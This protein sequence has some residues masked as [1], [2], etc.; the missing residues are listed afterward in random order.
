M[1]KDVAR[2]SELEHHPNNKRVGTTTLDTASTPRT[3]IR[4]RTIIAKCA[5]INATR[6]YARISLS[7]VRDTHTHIHI[8]EIRTV[9]RIIFEGGVWFAREK[10]KRKKS[11]IASIR[12]GFTSKLLYPHGGNAFGDSSAVTRG[13]MVKFSFQ[14]SHGE[15]ENSPAPSHRA[16][17]SALHVRMLEN[18]RRRKRE[19]TLARR[20]GSSSRAGVNG[21]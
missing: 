20:S 10:G 5:Q 19:N 12:H 13:A 1:T 21:L 17:I 2:R 11:P 8:A 15:N 7:R 16:T 9:P 4:S 18:S 3:T 6:T 14:F